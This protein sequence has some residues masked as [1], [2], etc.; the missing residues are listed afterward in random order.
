M[1]RGT[2]PSTPMKEELQLLQ[3]SLEA[4]RA[5]LEETKKRLTKIEKV[6][7]IHEAR[8]GGEDEVTIECT[9]LVVRQWND[10]RWIAIH[11]GSGEDGGY[12]D[13][14]HAGE[15]HAAKTAIGIGIQEDGEPHIQLRGKDWK[16][17]ADTFIEN[18]HGTMAVLAPGN[19]PGAVMRAR[20]GGG[21]VSVL[22]PD[23][24]ARAVLIHDE[25][26]RLPGSGT[27]TPM[28]DLIFATANA[29]TVLKLSANADG[30]LMCVGHPGQ[31]DASVIMSREEGATIML[32]SPARKT[33]VSIAAM[34]GMAR[35]AAHQ[36][37]AHES[38][39]EAG[40]SAG[41][42]GG[43][44]ELRDCDGAKRLDLHA[45]EKAGTVHLC[46]DEGKVGVSLTHHVGSHSSL[47][48][49][50]VADHECV[51]IIAKNDMSVMSVIAPDT[52]GT[53]IVSSVHAGAPFVMLRRGGHPKV[54]I[55]DGEQGGTVSAYGPDTERAG[56]ATLSGGPLAGSVSLASSDGI[57]LLSLDATDHG[58]RLLI[59]NDL[60][61][62]RIAMGVY[63][64]SA[65]LHLNH[66]GS[67]GVQA[68]A[69]PKGGLVSVCDAEGRYVETMPQGD[70]D[71]DS[72]RW[73]KLP[74]AE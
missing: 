31:P 54:M 38:M 14:H 59:N 62:Q 49:H 1:L 74:G 2:Q 20:P 69:T 21:S 50:G 34:D 56:I 64:E 17:R 51:R 58:G 35:M 65:G 29:K 66:T 12:I 33:S 7:S 24:K 23:G 41:A 11:L 22:Q 27:V 39:A 15:E 40:I 73:G 37:Q 44:M 4:M 42:F 6:V 48:M 70:D 36:G 25:H 32:N 9:T 3:S 72:Q 19:A 16:V 30:G 71:D 46:D 68:V 52:P 61:F 18:D 60:G 63:Q 47:A 28:T 8:D 55:N 13:V 67:L 10:R 26:H 45:A 57:P 53:E 43:S 5:E